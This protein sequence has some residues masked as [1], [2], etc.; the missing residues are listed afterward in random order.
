MQSEKVRLNPAIL[1]HSRCKKI[2]QPAKVQS[3]PGNVKEV[4]INIQGKVWVEIWAW[5]CGH[6][7]VLCVLEQGYSGQI[8]PCWWGEGE[9]SGAEATSALDSSQLGEHGRREVVRQM[10]LV[11]LLFKKIISMLVGKM[12]TGVFVTCAAQQKK[13]TCPPAGKPHSFMDMFY[14]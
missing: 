9:R 11:L 10:G 1:S 12:C 7:G 13:W 2:L 8:L 5:P 4:D 3:L 14:E 6:L